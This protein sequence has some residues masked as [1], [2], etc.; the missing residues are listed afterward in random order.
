MKFTFA[1]I[2]SILILSSC[3]MNGL[4]L[5]PFELTTESTFKQFDE[6][7]GDTLVLT[8]DNQANPNF[9]YQNGDAYTPE[10]TIESV[11]FPVADGRKLNAWIIEPTGES[12]GTSLFFT[13]G[14]A[15]NVVYNYQLTVPFVKLGYKVFL[16]DY[17][18]FG[19]SEGEAKRKE[20][21]EDALEAF[22][23]MKGREEFKDQKIVVYGQS[24]GGHLASVVGT[25]KQDQIDALVVEGGFNC[26][27]D[28]A[29]DRVP[30]LARIFVAEQYSGEDSIVNYT[31]PLLVIHSINDKV[32]PYKYGKRLYDAATTEKSFY[33]IDS[34][35]IRGPLY[36]T[37]SIDFRIQ[38]MLK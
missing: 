18:E 12:N 15:G 6:K 37:D 4:F 25:M 35:H 26:H 11:F 23:Y 31:K 10:F 8:F 5:H 2:V 20:V 9:R 34:A 30:V 16:V 19:F 21:L 1:L 27:K 22:D 29:A 36:Y 3:G 17:S 13:H 7:K 24:L 32:V 28:I 33:E 38:R 14:N